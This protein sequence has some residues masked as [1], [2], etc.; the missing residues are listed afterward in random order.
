[1]KKTIG[2]IGG[3]G[4]MATVDLYRKITELTPAD[5]D[6]EHLHLIIDS[7][8]NIEDRTANILGTGK[9]PTQ[10]LIRSALALEYMGADFLIMPCNTAH[11][12]YSRITP[13]IKIPFINMIEETAKKIQ[14]MNI[15]TVGL[16]STEGVIKSKVY[17]EIFNSYGIREIHPNEEGEKEVMNIIYNGI[18]ARN[19]SIDLSKFK[20]VIENLIL[21][22]AEYLVLG[23]TELPIAFEKF[24]IEAKIINPTMILAQ[25]AVD[26]ALDKI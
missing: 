3:M 13:F 15:K 26:M 6:N 17:T 14:G 20:E 11:F 16:L 7:N 22:G 18:K 25:A 23:C 21:E 9:D 10:E 8:T 24:N 12:Y 4:P 1:M 5:S 19:Y 2:I